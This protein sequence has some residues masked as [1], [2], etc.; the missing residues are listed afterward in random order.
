MCHSGLGLRNHRNAVVW[1][2]YEGRGI[3]PLEAQQPESSL[4][5]ASSTMTSPTLSK[6]PYLQSIAAALKQA[7]KFPPWTSS[8]DAI[9]SR[10]FLSQLT[11]LEREQIVADPE[12]EIQDR[13]IP[14][15]QGDIP[16]SVITRKAGEGDENKRPGMFF[17]HGGAMVAG[18]RFLGISVFIP[19]VKRMNVVILTVDYRLA[20]E[21]HGLALVTD[22]YAALSW[23]ARY[24]EDLSV[25]SSR[26]VVA[27]SSAGG[28]VAAGTV[29][30]ARDRGGPKIAAQ[31]LSTPMLDDRNT[32]VSAQQYVSDPGAYGSAQNRLAWSCVLGE[33]AGQDGVSY[34]IAPARAMD[35]SRLPATFVDVGGAEPFRDEA[36]DFAA[37]LSQAGVSTDL[38]VWGGC[39]HG[40]EMVPD[41]VVAE[42]SIRT[43][44]DWL[45]RM[46]SGTD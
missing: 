15:P 1:A 37:R 14:G 40:F 11:S 18:D 30:M 39:Q 10:E 17:I 5:D 2:A 24:A 27:G 4:N 3:L 41:L 7:P 35:L 28:G 38:H 42:S 6:Q 34:Y 25:D 36:I 29:L 26:I 19:L 22:A 46:F 23:F 33:K 44:H 21:H 31:M 20:P 16:V 32:T 8:Q 9:N 12:L 43:K 45:T 13:I